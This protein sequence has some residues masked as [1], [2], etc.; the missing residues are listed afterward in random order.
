MGA[1]CPGHRL[2]AGRIYVTQLFKNTVGVLDLTSLARWIP[3][4]WGKPQEM[5]VSGSRL[6][7]CNSVTGVTEPSPSMISPAE[8][9]SNA[10]GRLRA[11]GYR[12]R[13]RRS[14][15]VVCTG[16]SFAA[17]PVPGSL[18]RINPATL[19]VEDSVL[20]STPLWGTIDA[21]PE[22]YLYVLV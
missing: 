16:N 6:F 18:Y 20:F 14:S 9:G 22:G 2:R 19:G 1:A 11:D 17:P 13:I 5:L 15:L 10:A 7:I 12:G 4:R 21:S 3:L 8:G